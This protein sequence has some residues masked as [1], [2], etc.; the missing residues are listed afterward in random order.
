MSWSVTMKLIVKN[1]EMFKEACEE[2]NL[3]LRDNLTVYKGSKY[4]GKLTE[5]KKDGGDGATYQFV[6]DS[7]FVGRG[8]STDMNKVMQSYS[9]KV[10]RRG[11]GSIGTILERSESEGE[12][13]L[14]VCVNA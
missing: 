4:I 9:E 12:I 11:I 14:R 1:T 13:T 6:T 10:C 7:D 5:D 2:N 3:E 8:R